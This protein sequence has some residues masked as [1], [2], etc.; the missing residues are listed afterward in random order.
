MLYDLASSQLLPCLYSN[1]QGRQVTMVPDSR[2]RLVVTV[3]W[4][5]AP[6]SQGVWSR[7]HDGMPCTSCQAKVTPKSVPVGGAWASHMQAFS[8]N[9][10]VMDAAVNYYSAV[11]AS[12]SSSAG[13]L[14]GGKSS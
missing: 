11:E 4:P 3:A 9:A 5:G 7:C 6:A 12:Q 8:A 10:P 2:V 13:E 14:S 1:L